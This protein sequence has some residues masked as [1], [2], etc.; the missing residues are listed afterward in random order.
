MKSVITKNR[1]KDPYCKQLVY[2]LANETNK[3]QLIDIFYSTL[4]V[5]KYFNRSAIYC[6]GLIL[7]FYIT[8][9]LYVFTYLEEKRVIEEA[10]DRS[11]IKE[12]DVINTD[13]NQWFQYYHYVNETKISNKY[14]YI[15]NNPSIEELERYQSILNIPLESFEAPLYINQVAP[16]FNSLK[17][18]EEY[19]EELRTIVRNNDQIRALYYL[20]QY[21]NVSQ[22]S[23]NQI[24]SYSK[25]C[26]TLQLNQQASSRLN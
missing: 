24:L 13:L 2:Y 26:L 20:L 17:S 7:P 23:I 18:I 5:T 16:L 8:L 9:P 12:T 19:K 14:S 10:L 6:I 25:L 3:S 11:I 21:F 22:D 15:I 1:I 4:T